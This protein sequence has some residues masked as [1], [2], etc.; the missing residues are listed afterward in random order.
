[1]SKKMRIIGKYPTTRLRRVRS[2]DWVRRLV[3]ENSISAD[4]F[5]LP[6]FLTD[7]R[8]K[9]EKIPNMPGIFRYSVDNLSKILDRASKY[10]IPM[11][12]YLLIITSNES[13]YKLY[14]IDAYDKYLY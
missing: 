8:N 6:I 9:Q 12:E 1:M 10:K 2:S 3:A 13:L 11:K 5:I 4:D 7:G 14:Y